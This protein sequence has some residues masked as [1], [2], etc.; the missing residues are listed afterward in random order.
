MSPR[1]EI[2]LRLPCRP[3]FCWDSLVAFLGARAIPRVEAVEDGVYRRTFSFGGS[4]GIVRIWRDA[5]DLVVAVPAGVPKEAVVDRVRRLFDIDAEPQR[6]AE[7]FAR[8][9]LLGPLIAKWQGIRVPGAW[10]PFEIVVRAVVGQQISVAGART[11]LG[12]IAARYGAEIEGPDGLDLVF[13]EPE[14]LARARIGG[15]PASRAATIRAVASAFCNGGPDAERLTDI[16]GVGPWTASYVAMRA[17][18]A[19]DAFP[20]GDLG[21]RKAAGGI[22]ATELERVSERWRPYRAYAAMLLWR[23]L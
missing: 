15:M 20:A 14:R 22:S 9:P 21:L 12:R 17:Y 16:R 5:G 11:I 7:C 3:P 23:S 13:P 1:R 2:T 6:I 10:E 18:A 19:R 8:D 4:S